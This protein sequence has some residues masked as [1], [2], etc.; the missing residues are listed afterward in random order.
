MRLIDADKLIMYIADC[1]LSEIITW[2]QAEVATDFLM[3]A[4]T[5]ENRPKGKWDASVNGT[6]YRVC[7]KCGYERHA[8]TK[9][10]YC[11]ICGADMRGEE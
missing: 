6:D 1:K 10:N 9:Y 7:S 11:P 3:N 4:P 8:G 2:E 5:V